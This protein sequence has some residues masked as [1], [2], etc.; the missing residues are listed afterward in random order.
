MSS[1]GSMLSR[2]TAKMALISIPVL[3]TTFIIPSKLAAPGITSVD[4]FI[5]Q[6]SKAQILK[7]RSSLIYQHA[8]AGSNK[9]PAG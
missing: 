1:P 5:F 2:I 4:H 9:A 8:D 7:V 6:K 3:N